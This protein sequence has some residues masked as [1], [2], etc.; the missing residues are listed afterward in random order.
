MNE[1]V[2]LK[3]NEAMTTSLQV[4]EVFEKQHTKV[5]RAIENIIKGLP[6]NGDTPKLFSKSYYTHPQNNQKYPIYYMNRDGFSLLV[7]G[8][9]GK[10]A[11]EW[12]LKYIE[13]F[14]QMEQYINFRKADVMLQKHSM[15]FIHDNLQMPTAKDYMKANTIADK[16]VS[17]MNGYPKI[18]KKGDMTSKMLEQREAVLDDVVELMAVKD[19]YDMDISVSKS[20]YKRYAR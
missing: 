14:N 9:T 19:K 7:M 13:A 20:I 4:A 10:K 11:L 3:K 2:Y 15:Q 1:L 12:K 8:F 16:C 18:V 6:Q 17:N 5:I